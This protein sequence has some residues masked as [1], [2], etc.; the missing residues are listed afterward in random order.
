[1]RFRIETAL[2]P[3]PELSPHQNAARKTGSTQG[4]YT[5]EMRAWGKRVAATFP[6]RW[7]QTPQGWVP[8]KRMADPK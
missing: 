2:E 5:A 3:Q 7:E 4:L 8:R 6:E 1:M